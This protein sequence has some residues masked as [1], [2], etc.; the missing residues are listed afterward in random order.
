[1]GEPTG[2]ECAARVNDHLK[3]YNTEL[4]ADLFGPY[5]AFIETTKAD[6][7]K[8]G[9]PYSMIASY[10]PFCGSKYPERKSIFDPAKRDMEAA[11]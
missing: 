2:C 10:C 5:R 8:R 3:A 9:K 4:M 11:R 6:P 1:M 7:K